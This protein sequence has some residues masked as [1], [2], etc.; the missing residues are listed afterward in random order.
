[1]ARSPLFGRRIHI[2][3]SIV[4]DL[5]I[6][7]ADEVARAREFIPALV[8]G[9][10]RR[11]ATF[12]VPVDAEDTRSDGQPICFDWLI[13]QTIKESLHLRP[14]DAAVPLAVAVQHHK[15]EDQIPAEYAELWDGLRSSALVKLEN[16]AQ[17]NMNSKRMEAQARHGDI[18]V[19][20]GGAE[21][22]LYL[23]NLYHDAGKPVIPLPFALSPADTGSRRLYTFGTAS[24]NSHRLFRIADGGDAHDWVNRIRFPDREPL[25]ERV[26]AML[27]LMESLER[28]TAFAVR[29]L[30]PDHSDFAAVQDFFDMVVVPVVEGELGYQ[31]SVVDGRQAYEHSRIDQEIFSRLHRSS[32]VI[33]D[34]TGGRPNC[35]L[36][37]GYALGRGLSTIVTARKGGETPFD[38]ATF[39]GMHW[40]E[41]GAAEDRRRAFREH[42]QATRNRP[43]LVSSEGLI[44]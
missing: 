33:A 20:L 30:N 12:V 21:G 2:A 6:A 1:M 14:A 19:T 39:A 37:L 38:I 43:P 31:L 26:E 25:L 36:E 3:G 27:E 40:T 22:V 29:L 5:D 24:S 18:L 41:I 9:L 35:F 34:I 8:R 17:W 10:M 42:L 44:P 4:R 23:A 13:W 16:A 11:G 32:I 7:Q 28:P 15:N